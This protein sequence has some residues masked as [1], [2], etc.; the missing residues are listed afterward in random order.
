[1]SY[2]V[3]ARKW[4]PKQFSEVVG[5]QHIVTALSNALDSDRIHHAFLFMGTR[6]VGKTTLARI[7]AKALNCEEGV[8]AQPCGVC[9]SCQSVAKGNH[10]DLIE[11]DAASRT[12]VDDTR[13]LLD[14]VPYAPTQGRYKVYL[15]DEVHML[16]THSFNALLKTL[17]EPPEHVKFLLATTDPQKLPMTILSRCMQFSLNAIDQEAIV[18]QLD[19]I[20]REENIPSEPAALKLVARSACGS[21]RDALSLL[22]QAIAFS[23]ANVTEPALREMLG[24]T[25]SNQVGN[26]V[27]A[28]VRNDFGLVQEVIEVMAL[29]LADYHTALNDLLS[30]IHGISVFQFAPDAIEWKGLDNEMVAQYAERF[31]AEQLQLYYQIVAHGKRDLHLAPD[32]RTGFEMALLRLFAFTPRKRL[33]AHSAGSNAAK[34]GSITTITAPQT[35]SPLQSEPNTKTPEIA[36]ELT[37]SAPIAEESLPPAR[38]ASEE[39]FAQLS[40]HLSEQHQDKAQTVSKPTLSSVTPLAQSVAAEPQQNIPV[41]ISE[42]RLNAELAAPATDQLQSTQSNQELAVSAPPAKV[43]PADVIQNIESWSGVINALN[44]QGMARQLALHMSPVG[45]DNGKLQ[46][47]LDSRYAQLLNKD[48]LAQIQFKLNQ[49]CSEFIE[50][51]IEMAEV[52]TINTCAG[53][54]AV[55]A[56]Q[57]AEGTRRLFQEDPAVQEVVAM[58]DA[59][60]DVNSIKAT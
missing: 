27:E 7:F 16:S 29:K 34:S 23:N 59:T 10:I 18:G 57:Q 43:S 26:I 46:V 6:G 47:Q 5:Q 48:R 49:A 37:A 3:L 38:L 19:Y 36:L 22:D 32:R 42:Q 40:S 14:N 33:T 60:V 4:R 21:M 24:M 20:L 58:F 50:V 53:F 35:Q 30:L 15:I 12:K 9:V 1:M 52:D 51:D 45:F 13:D 44:L 39:T 31:S 8:S 55:Q 41:Q 56:K 17:E 11:V 28:L 25:D 2:Q 54:N